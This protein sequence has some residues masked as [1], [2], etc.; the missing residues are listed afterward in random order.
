MLLAPGELVERAIASGDPS[1]AA[2]ARRA[3]LDAGMDRAVDALTRRLNDRDDFAVL[4]T[5]N[6]KPLGA[7][8]DSLAKLENLI[9]D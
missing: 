8:F 6:I 7:Y 4:A 1:Q 2:A 5:V 9:A 3:L